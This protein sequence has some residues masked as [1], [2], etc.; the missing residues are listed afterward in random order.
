MKLE[1]LKSLASDMNLENI[2]IKQEDAI[3]SIEGKGDLKNTFPVPDCGNCEG[4]C[5]PPRVVIS[6]FDIARFIDN[7]LNEFVAGKFEGFVE[8]FLSEDGKNVKLHHPHMSP[9][10]PDAKVCVFLDKDGKCSIYENRPFVCRSYPVAVRI[11]EDRSKLALWLGGCQNYKISSDEA[12]FRRLLDSAIQDYNEKLSANALLMN[13][14]NHLRELGFGNY[15]EDEW[16]LLIDYNKKNSDMNM[17][18]QDLQQVVE[19]LRAP[20]DYTAII[21]RFQGDNDWLKDRVVNLEK[22]LAQQRE[23]A[24]SIISE[25]TTQLSDQRKLIESLRQSDKQVRKGLWRK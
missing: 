10:D 19:R 18:I 1:E 14:R 23:R 11:D 22:E 24:H 5:C 21:Q 7:G 12:A 6:L 16:Q 3:L 25:L 2:L 17:Q 4:K 13:R 20:Q 15:M 8:L 9:T